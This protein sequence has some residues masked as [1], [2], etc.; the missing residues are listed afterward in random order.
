[1]VRIFVLN[2]PKLMLLGNCN[3]VVVY[4]I[5]S[6]M[7]IGPL[8]LLFTVYTYIYNRELLSNKDWNHENIVFIFT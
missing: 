4:S 6:I 2:V 1:M 3:L 7:R 8:P 5:V